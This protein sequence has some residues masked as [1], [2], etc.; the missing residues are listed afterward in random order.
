MFGG[1]TGIYTLIV[2][3]SWWCSSLS[4]KPDGEHADCLR[5]LDDID[6]VLKTAINNIVGQPGTTS[7]A[8]STTLPLPTPQSYKRANPGETSSRKWMR[9]G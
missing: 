2:L 4:T 5:T 9:S 6:R 8:I 7:T 3:V 1:P